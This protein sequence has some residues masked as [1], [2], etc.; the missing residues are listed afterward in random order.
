MSRPLADY[1]AAITAALDAGDIKAVPGLLV[2]MA[3]DGYGHEAEQLRRELVLLAKVEP[4]K[5]TP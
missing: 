3:G 1:Y 2:L 5:W 4:E